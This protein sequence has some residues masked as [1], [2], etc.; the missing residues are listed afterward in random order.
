MRTFALGYKESHIS[1]EVRFSPSCTLA[2][3]THP[4]PSPCSMRITLL[5]P[6]PKAAPYSQLPLPQA[7]PHL[8]PVPSQV[9]RYPPTHLPLPL[10]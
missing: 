7:S 1:R 9:C 4:P 2:F 10:P 5:L 3:T 8:Q 6:L